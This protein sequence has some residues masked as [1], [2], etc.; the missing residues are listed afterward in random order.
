MAHPAVVEYLRANKDRFSLTVLR[1]QLQQQGYPE[2]VIDVC[3]AEVFGV[4]MVAPKTPTAR[5]QRFFDF[6]RP[7]IYRTIGQKVGH[8]LIG[9][10]VIPLLYSVVFRIS[11]S[12]WVPAAN[13][14]SWGSIFEYNFKAFFITSVIVVG[15]Y[16]VL[17]V[18]A[19]RYRRWV[20]WGMLPV[21][22]GVIYGITALFFM[23]RPLLFSP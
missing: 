14:Y 12:P 21:A 8:F 2:A 3:V 4:G 23:L 1:Q 6:R 22:V 5:P 15:I 11:T 16:I 7:F 20:F 17:W 10:V 13:D 19:F 18:Y 9:L